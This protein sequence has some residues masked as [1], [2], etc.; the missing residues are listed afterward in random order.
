M[1]YAEGIDALFCYLLACFGRLAV[2]VCRLQ[3]V[4]DLSWQVRSSAA[5]ESTALDGIAQLLLLLPDLVPGNSSSSSATPAPQ[6]TPAAAAPA[7]RTF[8]SGELLLS[9]AGLAEVQQAVLV[10][11]E[12]LQRLLG[13]NL[14]EEAQRRALEMLQQQQRQLRVAVPA[15]Y[16][17]AYQQS[18]AA[19]GAAAG[20]GVVAGGAGSFSR[21][22]L[23][24]LLAPEKLGF[25]AAEGE[26]CYFCY[27]YISL[28]VQNRL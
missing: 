8:A 6:G 7:L 26:L 13:S 4:A 25:P 9:S 3:D 18:R 15:K 20:A 14:A 23:M 1:V 27:F 28:L 17:V 10:S 12:L 2:C 22:C 16:G 19:V 21:L 11:L 5:T 24:G